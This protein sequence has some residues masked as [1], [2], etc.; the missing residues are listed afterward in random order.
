MAMMTHVDWLDPGPSVVLVHGTLMGALLAAGR[1]WPRARAS[2]EDTL[3][4]VATGSLLA[5]S[6]AVLLSVVA[7]SAGKGCVDLSIIRH[8]L[9]QLA[10][11][12]MLSDFARYWL[13]Y[14]H[15]RFGLLWRFHQ[16]H[17]SSE[18]LDA[19]AG[20]RMHVVDFLQLS[21][22]PIVL[23]GLVFDASSFDPR[24][25]P[26]LVILINLFDALQHADVRFTLRSPLARGWNLV[27]NNPVFHSWH[28]STDPGEHH[29]NYGQAL[30]I[31]DRLFGTHVAHEDPA[32][33]FGLPA[34]DRLDNT[35]IGL[36]LL[37]P[38]AR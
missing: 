28:H 18:T 17:H 37:R 16:V 10:T 5:G 9:L 29:G 1:L 23:F 15:H 4:N 8:P 6:R 30:T 12:F 26:A 3:L 2:A 38:R 13:H 35:L 11:V 31:W 24:V 20:L 19:T 25:W 22:V 33:A 32:A 7:I 21:L 27:L 14:A 34:E 36:Q